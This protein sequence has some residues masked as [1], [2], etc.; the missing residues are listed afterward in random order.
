MSHHLL[1]APSRRAE[2]AHLDRDG[3]ANGEATRPEARHDLVAGLIRTARP[4]QW[5]KNLLVLAAPM[6]A[7]VLTDP[8]VVLRLLVAVLAL[9]LAASS[10]YLLNDVIDAPADRLHPTKRHRPIAAG[11]VPARL[12]VG[13]SAA[14]LV[15]SVA[16]AFTLGIGSA[17]LVALYLTLTISY[18]AW[19]KKILFLDVLLVASGF[20]LRAL[21]GAVATGI[22]VPGPF[23]MVASFGALFLV[24]GKRHGERLKLGP[25]ASAH[26]ATLAAYTPTLTRSLV[27][28]SI[29]LT[30]IAYT[31][32]AFGLDH[33][34]QGLPWVALSTLPFAVAMLRA[35]RLVLRGDGA[36]PEDLLHDSAVALAGA[37]TGL[38][39]LGGLYVW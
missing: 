4:R 20:L 29:T 15:G 38:L 21:A 2:P 32:W 30:L 9:C 6:A 37:A 3:R 31:R 19:L 33:G 10:T 28:T 13:A 36:D 14:L 18:S 5:I 7:G 25:T 8:G 11:D 34:E 27:A 22:A 26:R 35:T 23:L 17:L 1:T 12:A 24:L 39:L 16:V